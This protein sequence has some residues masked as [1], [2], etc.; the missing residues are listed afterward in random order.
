MTFQ[1][2]PD[3][4]SY[5]RI[6]EVT[7]EIPHG[8][9]ATYG[10]VAALAGLPGHA[11][12]A[13]YAMAALRPGSDVPWQRV[14]NAKGEVSP[15]K[16]PGGDVHQRILLEREGIVFSPNGRVDLRKYRWDP[17]DSSPEQTSLFD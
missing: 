14:I 3:P 11:R 16:V 2:E 13:G 9:V 12:Q 10:Q 5:E 6:Y 4:S 17:D 8:K 15:R 1:Q 7:R